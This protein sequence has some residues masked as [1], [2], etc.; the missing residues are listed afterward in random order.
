M[1]DVLIVLVW[2]R[3]AWLARRLREYLVKVKIIDVS[4]IWRYPSSSQVDL[5]SLQRTNDTS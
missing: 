4:S 2:D 1:D 5:W 3:E